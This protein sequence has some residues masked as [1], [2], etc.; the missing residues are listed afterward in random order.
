MQIAL[1]AFFST[2][3]RSNKKEK[4]KGE[5]DFVEKSCNTRI[6]TDEA[7]DELIRKQTSLSRLELKQLSQYLKTKSVDIQ[8]N[9]FCPYT[10]EELAERFKDIKPAGVIKG[11][12][13]IWRHLSSPEE[14]QDSQEP[15]VHPEES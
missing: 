9:Q 8:Q 10:D 6:L 13:S 4:R 3:G 5:A 12:A 7:V 15:K 1:A 2:E 14:S 11:S